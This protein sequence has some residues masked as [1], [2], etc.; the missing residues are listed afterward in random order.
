MMVQ[1]S[2]FRASLCKRDWFRVQD[3]LIVLL[4]KNGSSFKLL[5]MLFDPKI[6]N[7]PTS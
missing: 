6:D 4:K 2:R 1:H 7:I 5:G 3:S